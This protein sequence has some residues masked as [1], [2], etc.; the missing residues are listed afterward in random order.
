MGISRLIRNKNR[1]G[2]FSSAIGHA[3]NSFGRTGYAG[4]IEVYIMVAL[5]YIKYKMI[6]FSLLFECFNPAGFCPNVAVPAF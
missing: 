1:F 4:K 6:T 3:P 2:A 5:N